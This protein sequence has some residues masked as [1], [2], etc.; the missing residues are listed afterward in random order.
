MRIISPKKKIPQNKNTIIDRQIFFSGL[1][2]KGMAV[3]G[4]ARIS[5][6]SLVFVVL[7]LI[8]FSGIFY[9]YQVNSMATK[10][11]EIKKA[12]Q[13][14]KELKQQGEELKI[15][16]AEQRSMDNIEKEVKNLD[17]VSTAEISY[18]EVHGPVAMR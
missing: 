11:I 7:G 14:I 17:L 4:S 16:E 8:A 10:G 12:E 2:K 5:L 15:K 9:L 1:K 18:L 3:S 13:E 6:V